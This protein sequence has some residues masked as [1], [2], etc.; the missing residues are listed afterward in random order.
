MTYPKLINKDLKNNSFEYDG[1]DLWVREDV[2]FWDDQ[3]VCWNNDILKFIREISS[4]KKFLWKINY[5]IPYGNQIDSLK[6]NQEYNVGKDNRFFSKIAEFK[7]TNL[8]IISDVLLFDP[9]LISTFINKL[10]GLEK[11]SVGI[12]LMEP[13]VFDTEDDDWIK[14]GLKNPNWNTS[15]FDPT[16]SDDIED[17]NDSSALEKLRELK[18]KTY[19]YRHDKGLEFGGRGTVYGF[20]AQEVKSVFPQGVSILGEEHVP[21]IQ[22]VGVYSSANKTITFT[23][24]DTSGIPTS[25]V[26]RVVTAK[27][28]CEY[29]DINYISIIDSHTIEVE[30]DISEHC[31]AYDEE[32]NEFI[33][34]NNIYV[35]GCQVP[36]FHLL[37]KESI[38][39]LA[40]AA[41]QEVDRQLQAEKAKTATLETKVATL[42][43]EN[44]GLRAD[45]E[46]IKAHLGLST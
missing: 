34:G 43:S 17:I 14:D 45:I 3:E 21:N 2:S 46:A 32:N 41:L 7:S 31:G 20:I 37:K 30:T 18:P 8:D 36:D 13:S 22:E 1:G 15:D 24:F 38:F 16:Q 12:N 29:L 25:G 33:A 19:K 39:T 40:T 26:I 5:T 35:E 28:E 23:N 11:I 44:I 10:D 42:E 6:P 27:N 4:I 9:K